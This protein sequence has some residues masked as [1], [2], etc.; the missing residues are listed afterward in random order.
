MA[1]DTSVYEELLSCLKS[2]APIDVAF[3]P[4]NEGT[5][6]DRRGIVGNM[7]VREAFELADES[8]LKR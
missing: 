4:V 3:L 5:F 6:R 8:V 1:G 7:S 2:V